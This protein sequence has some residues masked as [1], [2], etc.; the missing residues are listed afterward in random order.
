MTNDQ[1]QQLLT[2]VQNNTAT[3]E[4]QLELLQ[5]VNASLKQFNFLVS[6]LNQAIKE[7][8]VSAELQS[9]ASK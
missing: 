6:E 1:F 3:K 4:E 9:V 8:K 5:A 7:D 2:K